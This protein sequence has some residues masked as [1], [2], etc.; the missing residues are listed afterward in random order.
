MSEKSQHNKLEPYDHKHIKYT[1]E[2]CSGLWEYL[3][4]KEKNLPL[5]K[6]QKGS[7]ILGRTWL[8]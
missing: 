4:K 6:S 8:K 5:V 3:N 1:S 7:V 2:T